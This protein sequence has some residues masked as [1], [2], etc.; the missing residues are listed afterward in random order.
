MT[1]VCVLPCDLELMKQITAIMESSHEVFNEGFSRQRL[2]ELVGSNYKLVSRAINT[3]RQ[4][5]FNALLNEYRIKE[6]CRRLIDS[7]A[8]GH[9]TIE[10]I[11]NS[12]GYLSRS[13]FTAIFKEIMGLTPSAFQKMH[14]Q[15]LKDGH[16]T[17][18]GASEQE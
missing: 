12:V 10:G 15:D 11:A 17:S 14:E 4:C 8:Y 1:Q 3:C 6:A 9:Y 7:N 13:N 5:N 2:A 16:D 18:L